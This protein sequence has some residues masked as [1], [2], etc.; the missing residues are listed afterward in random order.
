MGQVLHG[1]ATTTVLSVADEA[2]IV[3]FRKHTLLPLDDCLYALQP[4]IPRGPPGRLSG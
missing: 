4:S 1:S 3:A 2:A